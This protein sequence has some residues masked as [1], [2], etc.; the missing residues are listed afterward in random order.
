MTRLHFH[1]GA[2]FN[3]SLKPNSVPVATMDAVDI[4]SMDSQERVGI[5]SWNP[6]TAHVH[7]DAVDLLFG[8]RHLVAQA[9]TFG[10]A[11]C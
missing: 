11:L 7:R 4:D 9:P 8:P 3:A 5:L 6:S 10:V 2:A 1:V